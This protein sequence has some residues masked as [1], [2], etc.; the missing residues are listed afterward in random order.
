MTYYELRDIYGTKLL[1]NFPLLKSE[2]ESNPYLEAVALKFTLIWDSE[3]IEDRTKIF[4]KPLF[5]R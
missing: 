3:E 1:E 4:A 5:G 2:L